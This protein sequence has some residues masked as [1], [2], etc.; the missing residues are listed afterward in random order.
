MLSNIYFRG[1]MLNLMELFNKK[2]DRVD[3]MVNKKLSNENRCNIFNFILENPGK[4]FS[5][6]MRALYMTK[7]GLGYHLERLVEEG[8]ID[9]KPHGIF[10]FYYPPGYE[11]TTKKLT[12]MQQEIVD[13]IKEQPVR[14]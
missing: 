1:N 3:G 10:K 8:L 2:P 13:I 12:P 7:R 4:H 5:E 14:T 11:E 9:A 6:I